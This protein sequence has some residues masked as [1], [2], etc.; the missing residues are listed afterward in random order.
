MTHSHFEQL[1]E[2]TKV[3]LLVSIQADGF[4]RKHFVGVVPSRGIHLSHA[5]N[6]VRSI[7]RIKRLKYVSVGNTIYSERV[8][9]LAYLAKVLAVELDCTFYRKLVE[10]L[11]V[12][13]NDA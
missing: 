10:Q 11:R 6:R 8:A 3:L 5:L 12:C 4:R 13:L 2:F 9:P 1:T 7:S